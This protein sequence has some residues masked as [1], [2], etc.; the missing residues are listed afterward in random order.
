MVASGRCFLGW[1]PLTCV[2]QPRRPCRQG[3][4][5]R[6]PVW[7]GITRRRRTPKR[8]AA[9]GNAEHEEEHGAAAEQQQLAAAAAFA[10]NA[11]RLDQRLRTRGRMDR[12]PGGAAHAWR[13]LPW[14]DG[15]SGLPRSPWPATC[16][17]CRIAVFGSGVADSGVSPGGRVLQTCS[18]RTCSASA[19]PAN[20]RV[21]AIRC[22]SADNLPERPQSW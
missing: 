3:Q 15:R 14:R 12:R 8:E 5:R 22:D 4:G 21:C 9:R 2:R 20:P 16:G 6:R 11:G 1:S 17:G 19:C 18:C 7:R 10:G 13:R